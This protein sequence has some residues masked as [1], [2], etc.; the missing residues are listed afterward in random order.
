VSDRIENLVEMGRLAREDAPDEEV[1]GLWANAVE[2]YED[3]ALAN[4]SPN[5]RLTSAY[6]AGRVAALALVRA[7]NLRVRARNHHEVT[8]AAAGF[9]GGEE[10]EGLFQEFQALRLERIQLE[11]G[12]QVKATVGDVEAVLPRVR[13]ILSLAHRAVAALRPG[14]EREITPP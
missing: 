5:R 9:V 10:L 8:L 12:W 6:D 1:V 13:R 14:L 4:R 2:A 7:A 11:Y 3:A